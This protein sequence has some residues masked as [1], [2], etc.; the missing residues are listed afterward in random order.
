M[1][2]WSV[3]FTTSHQRS[4]CCT[5]YHHWCDVVIYLT[6]AVGLDWETL[7][8]KSTIRLGSHQ[9]LCCAAFLIHFQ[10]E[11]CGPAAGDNWSWDWLKLFGRS[12]PHYAAELSP[13]NRTLMRTQ[14]ITHTLCFLVWIRD[15]N[16]CQ[17]EWDIKLKVP[18]LLHFISALM[19][20][21]L[22]HQNARSN[23]Q[24]RLE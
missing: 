3:N 8:I 15:W 14:R 24:M 11:A 16:I 20:G 4:C 21:L 5:E 23:E 2:S 10:W 19:E 12:S 13:G 9:I 6:S 22:S 18:A 1:S 7:I 17:A